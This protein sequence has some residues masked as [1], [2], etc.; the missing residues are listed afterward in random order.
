VVLLRHDTLSPDDDI[1]SRKTLPWSVRE[2]KLAQDFVL[3]Y[4][5]FIA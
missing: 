5:V 1:R 4:I 2:G 3:A